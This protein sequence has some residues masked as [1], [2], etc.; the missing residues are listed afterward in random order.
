[1][2]EPQQRQIRAMSVTYTTAHGITRSLTQLSEARDR[3]HNLMVASQICF[4]CATMGTPRIFFFFLGPHLCHMEVPSLGVQL[5][6][7]L[8]A[9]A[10]ATATRDPNRICNLHHSSWQ[11]RIL[12]PLSKARVEP[13]SSWILAGFVSTTPQWELPN[14]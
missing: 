5:E 6:S 2:P 1:M 13:A 7:Q 14:I 3:T 10:M 11:H 9:Y 12:N 8:P 4:R